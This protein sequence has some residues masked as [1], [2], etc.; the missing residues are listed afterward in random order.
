MKAR[1][2]TVW[3]LVSPKNKIIIET[4]APTRNESWTLAFDIVS[5]TLGDDWRKQFWK[6]WPESIASARTNG[7]RLERVTVHLKD[8]FLRCPL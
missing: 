6:R 3:A 5:L 4:L 7:W 8:P 2:R 1:S